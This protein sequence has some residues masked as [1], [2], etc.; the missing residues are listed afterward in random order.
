MDALRLSHKQ[1]MTK[2]KEEWSKEQ[3]RLIAQQNSST[4]KISTLSKRLREAKTT[5]LKSSTKK[6]R[7]ARSNLKNKSKNNANNIKSLE[8]TTARSK[9][10]LELEKKREQVIETTAAV[11]TAIKTKANKSPLRSQ[12]IFKVLFIIYLLLVDFGL[13]DKAVEIKQQMGEIKPQLFQLLF[14]CGGQ[15]VHQRPNG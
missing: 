9:K 13:R 2:A 7:P 10:D 12:S 6:N 3:L 5:A 14:A 8:E 4:R 11:Q 1:A 15:H